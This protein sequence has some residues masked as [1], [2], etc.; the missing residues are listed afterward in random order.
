LSP[1]R[2]GSRAGYGPHIVHDAVHRG[3]RHAAALAQVA[4][5]TE[6]VLPGKPHVEQ[7]YIG[8]VVCQRRAHLRSGRGDPV[9]PVAQIV[10]QQLPHA[11]VIVDDEDALALCQ[12]ATSRRATTGWSRMLSMTNLT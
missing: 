7:Y 9:T 11:G 10:D 4:R 2:A 5:Q 6:P 1:H 3:E 12:W 8:D